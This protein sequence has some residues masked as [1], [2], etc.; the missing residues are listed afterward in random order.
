MV[1]ALN[2]LR[3]HLAHRLDSPAL[4]QKIVEFMNLRQTHMELLHDMGP[5]NES[6]WTF[7]RLRDD[8]SL[9]IAQLYGRA[10]TVRAAVEV[11]E[12]WRVIADEINRKHRSE[13]SGK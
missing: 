3:N 2:T 6:N 7:D 9:L 13:Q 8:I 12:P 10:F 4:T 1:D 5:V 11:V